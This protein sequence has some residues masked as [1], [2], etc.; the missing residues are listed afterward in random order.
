MATTSTIVDPEY[1]HVDKHAARLPASTH[2]LSWYEIREAH[3]QIDH[4]VERAARE[5][6]ALVIEQEDEGF[7]ILHLC[8]DAFYFLLICRWRNGNEL[9]E[10]V[11]ARSEGESEFSLVPPGDTF[12]T[13]CVWELAVV[14][15]QRAA[16]IDY[17]RSDRTAADLAAY[18]DFPFEGTV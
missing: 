8:G 5:Q 4:G 12:A 16:W 1:R 13:F 14:A 3:R 15:A 9:W 11:Y 2:S 17:L 6:A 7:V 10:T 18:R